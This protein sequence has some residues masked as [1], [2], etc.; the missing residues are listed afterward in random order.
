MSWGSCCGGSPCSGLTQ[1]YTWSHHHGLSGRSRGQQK[2]GGPGNK[3]S[4]P[5]GLLQLG[6]GPGC[7]GTTAG[8]G[9]PGLRATHRA[10]PWLR[11]LA[12]RSTAP[13]AV[14]PV[15]T[16][17]PQPGF[18]SRQDPS[19]GLEF[20]HSCGS[21]ACR[22]RSPSLPFPIC[23]FHTDPWRGPHIHVWRSKEPGGMQMEDEDRDNLSFAQ[24]GI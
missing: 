12:S 11:K 20:N 21:V 15:V 14:L 9:Q 13:S 24:G 3:L 22:A 6:S 1:T 8:A 19:P 2:P 7:V 17:T 16:E 5:E 10:S 18:P 23:Q 4:R